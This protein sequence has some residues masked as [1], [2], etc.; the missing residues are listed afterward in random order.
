MARG[1]CA[2]RRRYGPGP[3][4][5]LT[6]ESSGP[7]SA[8]LAAPAGPDSAT[9]EPLHTDSKL[10][11]YGMI[12][13]LPVTSAATMTV[14]S[15]SSFVRVYLIDN[16]LVHD[17]A[18]VGSLDDTAAQAFSTLARED[19]VHLQL[20]AE[21]ARSQ[22]STSHSK[23]IVALA[24][25]IVYG[26]RDL[27]DDVGG[28]LDQCRYYLQDPISC[29]H[30]VPYINP[31]C[32]PGL[33]EHPINTFDLEQPHGLGHYF[34]ASASLRALEAADGLPEL[35]QPAA[36]KTE[37]RRHQKQALYFFVNRENSSCNSH[38]WQA[39]TSANGS[40]T[41]VNTITGVSQ[42]ASPP[43]WSGGILA[44]EMGLGKTLQMI[45][46]IAAGKQPQEQFQPH[47]LKPKAALRQ[48]SCVARATLVVVPL[49]VMAVWE[50]QLESHLHSGTL[51]WAR[52]HRQNKI[53]NPPTSAWPDIVLTTYSTVQAEFKR[54]EGMCAGGVLFDKYWRR[55]ILDE[56]HQVRNQIATSTAIASLKALSRWAITGTPIQNS[57]TDIAGL[58]RFLQ[59]QPYDDAKAFDHDIAKYFRGNDI[60]E[61]TRRL[62]AL[63][64]PIMLRRSKEVIVLPSRQDLVR[65]VRFSPDEKREYRRIEGGFQSF[66]DDDQSS[67][68]VPAQFST[69][70]LINKLR[71]F[72][73]LGLA[74]KSTTLATSRKRPVVTPGPDSAASIVASD[75]ALGGTI[76]TKCRQIVDATDTQA[77]SEIAQGAYFSQ[78]CQVY[79]NACAA[80]GGYK[81]ATGCTCN[82]YS[83][84]LLQAVPSYLM[85]KALEGHCTPAQLGQGIVSSKVN[86][87]VHEVLASPSEKGVVFS[88]W[89]TSLRMVQCALE[90][91]G[92]WCVQFDGSVPP[93]ARITAMEQ[94]RADDNIKVMLVTVSSGGVGLDL[95]RA[96]RV[97][98]LEPQWNPAVENQAL[99]RV[100]RMG[101]QHPVVT[102]RYIVAESIEESP[103]LL[104]M[105]SQ[106]SSRNAA[107]LSAFLLVTEA[108]ER[109]KET[110]HAKLDRFVQGLQKYAGNIEALSN[111]V[112]PYLPWIWAPYKLMLQ[113]TSDYMLAFDKLIDAYDKIA[114]TL[115]R[116]NLLADTF[117]DSP[118]MF[119][120][121]ALYYADVL[122]FHR[123]AYKFVRRKSWKFFFM[124]TW[125][126]FDVRFNA[127]LDSLARHSTSI[128]QEATT[129]DIV[130]AKKWRET[131]AAE[132]AAKE[133]G[134]LFRQRSSVISWL[135]IDQPSQDDDCERLLQD[136]AKGSCDWMRKTPMIESW[137]KAD[138]KNPVLWL[139]GKPGAGKTVICASLLDSLQG[140]EDITLMFYFCKYNGHDSAPKVLKA[141][142]L[143]LID[144]NPNLIAVAFAN[145]VEKCQKPSLKVLREMLREF[146][147][148]AIYHFAK[149]EIQELVAQKPFA[150][151][152]QHD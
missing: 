151:R 106:S 17:G 27:A 35:E 146:V 21:A 32:L 150:G 23:R 113:A 107:Q 4:D 128:S 108:V 92:I 50:S 104:I 68:R 90:E 57:V 55:I 110:K 129:I 37:L 7:I 43:A 66:L 49:N 137:L 74:S 111:G 33:S 101:Q 127:I 138:T 3:T 65:T 144:S 20:M 134:R 36:L 44:D 60:A 54:R 133:N 69:I 85:Q 79:C 145:F 119:E 34:S 115:P 51:S 98:L 83:P 118:A 61:G 141:F 39:K 53:L 147:D 84:C 152:R 122:E 2:K 48:P 22:S 30:N 59:F 45:A 77:S 75:V 94:F 63:C 87:L 100:H 73:N 126:N 91:A 24:S 31:H 12:E 5:R 10:V 135:D 105:A 71:V 80:L 132:T 41:Y 13:K 42:D 93:S 139:H 114:G 64:H 95:T 82:G 8:P 29:E 131:M 11:C 124:T 121:L 102:M 88:F 14:I 123:R 6:P 140:R 46:L 70:Q 149:S 142:V 148:K 15:N 97:H 130:E 67:G 125:A 26:P 76:C 99:A 112:S 120:K 25:V 136:C 78:C 143:R 103:R 62:K 52:H 81:A 86:A 117:K 19:T 1:P 109:F 56:A 89:I 58:L 9:C 28:F 72:C 16:R 116:L 40:S 18:C 96:S 47:I 38:V